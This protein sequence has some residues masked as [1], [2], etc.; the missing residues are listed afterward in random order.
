MK[1]HVIALFF[2]LFLL[3]VLP[4][5]AHADGG[6][7]WKT[8]PVITSV[9]ES[10]KEQLIVEWD[11]KADLYQ[12]YLDG[13]NVATVNLNGAVIDAKAGRHQIRVVPIMI[14]SKNIDTSFSFNIEGT[15]AGSSILGKIN[16]GSIGIDIDLA[17]LGV[18]PKDI[19]QGSQSKTFSFTYNVNPLL[20][21]TPEV[22]AAATDFDDRVILSFTDK[23]N[24][25]LYRIGIKS[26]KDTN[27]VVF[28]PS[29]P[30]VSALVTKN[31]TA[32]TVILDPAYLKQ[33]GCLVP[34][35]DSK[36]SFSVM[37]EKYAVD[38]VDN[39][40]ET[41]MIHGSKESRLFN[42]TPT[43]AWKN[44]PEITYASQTADG[45]ITLQWVHDD[46]GIGCEYEITE[47]SKTMGVRRGKKV[48]GRTTG[49][50]YVIRDRMNGSYYYTITPVHGR[51]VGIA[52]EDAA[53]DVKNDWVAA[54]AFTAEVLSG[55]KIRLSWDAAPGV[56]SYHIIAYAGSGSLLRYVNLDFKKYGEYDVSVSGDKVTYTFTY[57]EDAVSDNGAR[58]RFE[59]Y[60]LRHDAG[61]AEQHSTSSKQTVVVK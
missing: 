29:S 9:Y 48:L 40:V 31:N 41:S 28:D 21:A 36:Y 18:D 13:K 34:E 50:E 39:A 17:A 25:D 8:A 6:D 7:E 10:G 52:S 23:Y 2:V 32:V 15:E 47:I 49:N 42:Y 3:F 61:G 59:I 33:N 56:E 11:G 27:Y 46:G 26:G 57:R 51:Q 19:L 60:G 14:S 5:A 20:S 44:A 37:L 45:Q 24:S 58:F 30:D 1:K 38:L 35:L 22:T 16:L 55:R 54:P 4:T 53:V 43:A 12:V